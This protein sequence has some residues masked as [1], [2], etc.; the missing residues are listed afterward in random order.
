MHE[1]A[2]SKMSTDIVDDQVISEFWRSSC[3]CSKWNGKTC[4]WQFSISF[5][6]EVR[7]HLSC[8]ELVLIILGQLQA[9]INN[10]DIVSVESRHKAISRIRPYFDT[11]IR[12][13]QF[14]CEC[15]FSFTA[16]VPNV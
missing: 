9:F 15:S 7:M 12:K 13:S 8:S 4:V 16:L 2:L 5:I 3:G 6:Q 11:I 10:S 14:A 1:V